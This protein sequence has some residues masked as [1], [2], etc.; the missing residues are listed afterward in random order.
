MDPIG[1]APYKP[2]PNQIRPFANR[3]ILASCAR[4]CWNFLKNVCFRMRMDVAIRPQ[5]RLVRGS[6]LC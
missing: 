5:C 6:T 4:W 3:S 1:V 2:F